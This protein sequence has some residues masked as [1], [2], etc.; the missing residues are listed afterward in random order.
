MCSVARKGWFFRTGTTVPCV[1]R[2][3]HCGETIRRPPTLTA[4]SGRLERTR[5][6]E[7]TQGMS[8][9]HGLC[10]ILH[11]ELA[12][13]VLNVVLDRERTDAEHLS[14]RG[15]ALSPLHPAQDLDLTPGEQ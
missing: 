9:C 10:P 4:P 3:K 13:D 14:D 12:Q 2:L 5:G 6:I 1:S 15:V 8:L 11:V 7:N